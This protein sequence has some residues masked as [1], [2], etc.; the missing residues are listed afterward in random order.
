MATYPEHEKLAQISDKSQ[1]IG[2]FMD[3]LNE[4][5]G[6]QLGEWGTCLD[7]F[8]QEDSL[9]P[10]TPTTVDLLAEHFGIDQNKLEDEKQAMLEAQR[11][12][13]RKAQT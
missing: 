4:T 12:M 7:E 2:E 3:W 13:N 6:F 11:E 5:K 8:C 1:A 10:V 9:H